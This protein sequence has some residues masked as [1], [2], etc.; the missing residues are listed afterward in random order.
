MSYYLI[1][2]V[3]VIASDAIADAGIDKRCTPGDSIWIGTNEEGMPCT[4]YALGDTTH[5]LGYNGTN[6]NIFIILA[7]Y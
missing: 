5:P 7:E 4:W 2:D 1:D 6:L 3:S